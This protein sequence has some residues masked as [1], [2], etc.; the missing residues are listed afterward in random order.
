MFVFVFQS[1]SQIGSLL[2]HF[3]ISILIKDP[4][5]PGREHV[6]FSCDYRPKLELHNFLPKQHAVS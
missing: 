3:G 1:V 4:F 5:L 6:Y 2:I